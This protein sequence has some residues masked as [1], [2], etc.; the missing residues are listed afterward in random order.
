[1]GLV[2]V[3]VLEREAEAMRPVKRQFLGLE[4]EDMGVVMWQ[5]S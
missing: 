1:M 3:A 4:A 5:F 2:Y